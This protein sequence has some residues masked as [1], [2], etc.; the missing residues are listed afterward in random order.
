LRLSIICGIILKILPLNREF[1]EQMERNTGRYSTAEIRSRVQ[2]NARKSVIFSEEL[3]SE[4]SI[5]K[6]RTMMKVE[7]GYK[8]ALEN[9]WKEEN[10]SDLYDDDPSEFKYALRNP[11]VINAIK[12]GEYNPSNLILKFSKL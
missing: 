4:S 9:G 1:L 12:N 7:A 5:K 2:N 6:L 3:I 8:T 11:E 10:L